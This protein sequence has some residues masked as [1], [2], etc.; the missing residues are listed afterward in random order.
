MQYLMSQCLALA[1]N[2]P[3]ALTTMHVNQAA[4]WFFDR[5]SDFEFWASRFSKRT[6]Q[7]TP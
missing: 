5:R 2:D 7:S 6:K 1:N 4:D 3:S